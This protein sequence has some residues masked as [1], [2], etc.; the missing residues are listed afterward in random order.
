MCKIVFFVIKFGLVVFD[1][2]LWHLVSF[3]GAMRPQEMC[4]CGQ[5]CRTKT[6]LRFIDFWCKICLSLF[7]FT[8]VSYIS[9]R[10]RFYQL[11]FPDHTCHV[12]WP[13]FMPTANKLSPLDQH[14]CS[15]WHLLWFQL[16]INK[17]VAGVKG[18]IVTQ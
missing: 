16:N 8:R 4:L 17:T 3:N 9:A 7:W 6:A 5:V 18:S 10:F 1:H 15:Q 11:K 2:N 13:H 14:F 12:F